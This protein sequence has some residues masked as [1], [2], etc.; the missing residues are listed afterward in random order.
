MQILCLAVLS[1]VSLVTAVVSI[2]NP[3]SSSSS[4]VSIQLLR[5][6]LLH[7]TV[8]GQ[9]FQR[10]TL[11]EDAVLLVALAKDLE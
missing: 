7:K 10:D 2:Q 8:D 3:A 5:L 11:R 9:S 4:V 1:V 6:G